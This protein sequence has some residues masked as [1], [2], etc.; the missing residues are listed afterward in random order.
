MLC[1]IVHFIKVIGF[2]QKLVKMFELQKI[3][4]VDESTKDDSA[5]KEQTSAANCDGK[6]CSTC[7]LCFCEFITNTHET[8]KM[9]TLEISN[10]CYFSGDRDNLDSNNNL[11]IFLLC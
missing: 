9:S 6:S 11:Y 5:L 7:S 10:K 8:E 2:S 1:D 3:T 4:C